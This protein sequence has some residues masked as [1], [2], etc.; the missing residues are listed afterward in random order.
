MSLKQ[1][2]LDRHTYREASVTLKAE[3]RSVHLPAK[4]GHWGLGKRHGTDPFSEL[5]EGTNVAKTTILDL[6]LP[7]T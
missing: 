7:Q 5:S 2:T 4:E 1:R 6:K 3:V